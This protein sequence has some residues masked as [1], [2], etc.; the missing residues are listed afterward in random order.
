L[1]QAW[2]LSSFIAK[3]RYCYCRA[4]SFMMWVCQLLEGPWAFFS[5]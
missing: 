3:V 5:T 4:L 2:P 1:M